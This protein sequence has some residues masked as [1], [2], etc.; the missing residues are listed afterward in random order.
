MSGCGCGCTRLTP[1]RKAGARFRVP[2]LAA[3]LLPEC[4][5]SL[6]GRCALERTVLD[7]TWTVRPRAPCHTVL[8]AVR[9]TLQQ[10]AGTKPGDIQDDVFLGLTGKARVSVGAHITVNVRQ[11]PMRDD[12]YKVREEFD[13][14]TQETKYTKSATQQPQEMYKNKRCGGSPTLPSYPKHL[15]SRLRTVLLC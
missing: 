12:L 14:G 1:A 9:T 3:S 7:R 13:E 6:V 10:R 15:W 2:F 11:K 8:R 4:L 5:V